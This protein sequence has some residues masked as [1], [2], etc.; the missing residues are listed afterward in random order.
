MNTIQITRKDPLLLFR[1]RRTWSVLVALPLVFIAIIGSSTGQ[2][3]SEAGAARKIKIGV[4]DAQHSD[5]SVHVVDELHGIEA[6][7]LS[8]FDDRALARTALAEDKIHVMLYIGP[9]Y[10]L[11]VDALEVY[12]VLHPEE[13]RLA[14][15]L[16]NFDIA[17]ESGSFL[18]N[19]SELVEIVVFAKTLQTIAGP[20][21][22]KNPKLA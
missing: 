16:K 20:V 22:R 7:E 2:L 19:A 10:D 1:D 21:V 14:G 8:T 18:A 5:Q 15:K 11:R 13:G 6:L 3:F 4:V 17:V 12:D 9:S